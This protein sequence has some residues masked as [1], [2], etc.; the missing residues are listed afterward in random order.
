VDKSQDEYLRSVL[1]TVDDELRRIA[2]HF[3]RNP[4]GLEMIWTESGQ[5]SIGGNVE[6]GD[7]E[8]HAAA[9]MV[10]LWPSWARDEPGKSDWVVEASIYVDCQHAIDHESMENVFSHEERR[11]TP[12]TAV[13][14]LLLVTRELA[15][16]AMDNP[17]EYWTSKTRDQ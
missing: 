17:I 13:D 4:E 11:Q 12:E 3:H 7:S 5:L 10:D 14:E 1:A 6:T 15:R 8:S 2:R 16:L 9:F